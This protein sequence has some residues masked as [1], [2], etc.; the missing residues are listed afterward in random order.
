MKVIAVD[1]YDREIY[2]DRL[3]AENLTEEAARQ[4]ADDLN[5][6]ADPEGAWFYKAVS[7]ETKLFTCDH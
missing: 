4:M 2:D 5:R 3:I 6:K 7:D 1:N